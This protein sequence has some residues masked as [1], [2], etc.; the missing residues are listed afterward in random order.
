MLNT[1]RAFIVGL[2]WCFPVIAFANEGAVALDLKANFTIQISKPIPTEYVFTNGSNSP[3]IDPWGV[4]VFKVA[5]LDNDGCDDVALEWTDSF[6]SPQIFYG[7]STGVL[8][9]ENVFLTDARVRSIRQFEFDDLNGDGIKDIFGFTAPH[10]WKQKQLGAFWDS[11]EPEFIAISSGNR[12]YQVLS[13][14]DETYSHTGL[15]ADVNNDGKTEVLQFTE[16]PGEGR[17]IKLSVDSFNVGSQI[18]VNLTK[19]ALFH[20]DTADINGDGYTDTVITLS[21]SHR[22]HPQ[23]TPKDASKDGT[24]AIFLGQPDTELSSIKPQVLGSHWMDDDDWLQFLKDKSNQDKSQAYAGTSNLELLD[25]DNDGLPEILVGYFV[26][27]NS[28]WMTSG[29]Q[30]LKFDGTKFIDVTEKL[31]PHQPS[32]RSL[33]YPSG[34]MYDASTA[35]LNNDGLTDLV[36]ALRSLDSMTDPNSSAVFYLNNG[37]KFVPVKNDE[38]LLG[39]AQKMQLIQ[40]G[41]FNCDGKKDLVGLFHGIPD[42]EN[43]YLKTLITK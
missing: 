23:V 7:N 12:T 42:K 18:Q 31:L 14:K 27:A 5:D 38:N 39:D 21:K 4:A 8:I 34:L 10:G 37:S 26:Q 16:D 28:P 22:K 24:V 1:S 11:D 20:A 41:D 2:A 3:E 43:H 13:S 32:N 29:M 17:T 9:R 19:H 35:D 15:V 30:V 25:L 6:S 40:S 36:V 33:L